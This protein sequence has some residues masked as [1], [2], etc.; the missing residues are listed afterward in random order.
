MDKNNVTKVLTER[1]GYTQKRAVLL[2]NECQNISEE[3]LPLFEKWLQ[4]ASVKEDFTVQG[5]SLL[6]MMQQ[7]EMHY[8]AALLD[9]DWL[10]KE[11]EKA[12]PVIDSFMK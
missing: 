11:P 7:R 12:K 6:N 1:E 4:D 5:Y 10:I 3:L 8:L 2:A 9:M